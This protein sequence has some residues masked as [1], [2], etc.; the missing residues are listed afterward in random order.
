M[1]DP[2]DLSSFRPPQPPRPQSAGQGSGPADPPPN[3]TGGI[4]VLAPSL[5]EQL[6]GADPGFDPIA[7]AEQAGTALSRTD[8]SIGNAEPETVAALQ[9]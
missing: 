8:L 2:I 6:D 1:V 9:R 5:L 4:D 3:G 7:L